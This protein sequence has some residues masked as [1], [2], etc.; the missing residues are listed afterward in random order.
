MELLA[1]R[2]PEEARKILDLVLEHID[3]GRPPLRDGEPGDGQWDQGALRRHRVGASQND[4]GWKHN[5]NSLRSWSA[6]GLNRGTHT[7]REG[8]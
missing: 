6:M 2:D 3:G 8:K 4:R 1:D 7:L 5:R